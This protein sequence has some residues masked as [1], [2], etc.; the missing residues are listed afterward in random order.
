MRGEEGEGGGAGVDVSV[1]E[2]VEA[3]AHCVEEFD[4]AEVGEG[5]ER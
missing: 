5:V 4:G 3:G 2:D 1:D